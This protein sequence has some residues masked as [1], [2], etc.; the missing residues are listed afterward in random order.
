MRSDYV[1]TL[2]SLKKNRS[3]SRTSPNTIKIM[4]SFIIGA[5]CS[6][7]L[8][9]AYA[10]YSPDQSNDLVPNMVASVAL[11]Q[12][13]SVLGLWDDVQTHVGR[14]YSEFSGQDKVRAMQYI[15]GKMTLPPQQKAVP[16]EYLL[17]NHKQ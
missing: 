7:V 3:L 17:F 15:A 9:A 13:I 16:G 6:V 11:H 14:P 2:K 10:S 8:T 12:K 1:N 4:T 5:V